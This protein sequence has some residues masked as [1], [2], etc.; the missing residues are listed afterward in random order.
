MYIVSCVKKKTFQKQVFTSKNV[1][2]D[3]WQYGKDKLADAC[4]IQ[5]LNFN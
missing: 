1:K 3:G 2:M 4:M 5:Y